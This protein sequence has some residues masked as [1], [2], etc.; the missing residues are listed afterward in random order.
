MS[1]KFIVVLF[2]FLFYSA[3]LVLL[4]FSDLLKQISEVTLQFMAFT[5]LYALK[6]FFYQVQLVFSLL[7]FQRTE[8]N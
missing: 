4:D 7:H 2:L 5:L 3:Q 6:S 8:V 1:P